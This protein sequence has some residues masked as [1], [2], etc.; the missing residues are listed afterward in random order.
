MELSYSFKFLVRKLDYKLKG[1]VFKWMIQQVG[2]FKILTRTNKSRYCLA[3]PIFYTWENNVV[4]CELC[5]KFPKKRN[6]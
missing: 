6:M 5:C 4:L 3:F 1:V 2:T